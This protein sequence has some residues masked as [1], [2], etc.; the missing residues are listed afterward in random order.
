M[1]QFF[2]GSHKDD[3]GLDDLRRADRIASQSWAKTLRIGA[4][5]PVRAR[6]HWRRHQADL[7]QLESV[8]NDAGR[9]AFERNPDFLRSLDVELPSSPSEEQLVAYSR[10]A[11][12]VLHYQAVYGTTQDLSLAHVPVDLDD[13]SKTSLQ[14]RAVAA[15]LDVHRA[16]N[17]S[18]P[19]AFAMEAHLVRERAQTLYTD[20]F[21]SGFFEVNIDYRGRPSAAYDT[22]ESRR[23][24]AEFNDRELALMGAE[25]RLGVVAA[26]DT[27]PLSSARWRPVIGNESDSVDVR[28]T[29][30]LGQLAF[31][32]GRNVGLQEWSLAGDMEDAQGTGVPLLDF[33]IGD[34]DSGVVQREHFS[35]WLRG[36]ERAR[37]AGVMIR[38]VSDMRIADAK[39]GLDDVELEQKGPRL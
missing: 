4:G 30:S 16:I 31:L 6:P 17:G 2:G 5:N 28:S 18:M 25:T 13:W 9:A 21:N 3:D 20:F 26:F 39:E 36:P 15:L 14:V 8:R 32:T 19:D 1:R 12:A 35:R 24:L 29:Y 23:A 34:D 38:V 22:D 33:L 37:Q 10:A 27:Q 7:A 11:G